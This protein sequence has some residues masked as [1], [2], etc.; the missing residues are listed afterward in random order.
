V[1]LLF[2]NNYDMKRAREAWKAGR[3]PAHHLWG[4]A[5]LS[6]PF[7]VQ[8]LSRRGQDGMNRALS[9]LDG[10][11]ERKLG[12][13]D[14]QAQV[15]RR[16]AG[17]A[18][19][20]AGN[21]D[22]T[23]LLALG[24]RAGLFRAPLV[25]VCH[26]VPNSHK[27]KEIILSAFRGYD[28]V[29]SLSTYTTSCLLDM[30]LEQDRVTTLGWGPD[31]S[32]S[33]Y[34][35]VG[36]SPPDAPVLSLG[37][38]QRDIPT[39]I[40]ALARTGCRGRIYADRSTFSHVTVPDTVEVRPFTRSGVTTSDPSYNYVVDDLRHAALVAIPLLST[41]HINGHTGLT[42]LGEAMA[43]GRPVIATK[44]SY[45]DVDIERIGCGWW[46]KKGDVDGWC[47]RLKCAFS[48]RELLAEM[49]TRGRLWAEQHWNGSRFDAGVR[50][51][52]LD[53]CHP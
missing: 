34:C 52:L 3:L 31:L 40:E 35:D 8:D 48:D 20:Y 44:T 14:L 33:G 49:G 39:L 51:V 42:E 18:A 26:R 12:D 7:V 11:L 32:F 15:L 28:R 50:Q 17:A 13:V 2:V 5:M 16:H 21:L 23:R 47:E 25:G 22:V 10:R 30:G 24:K 4:T 9:Y 6:D 46:V 1:K 38:T 53:V 45:F 29:I 43:C 19:V 27:R 37:R 36:A 41:G